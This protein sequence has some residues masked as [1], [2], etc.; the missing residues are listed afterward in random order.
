M[1]KYEPFNCE[2]CNAAD[3]E[4]LSGRD[5]PLFVNRLSVAPEWLLDECYPDEAKF[6]QQKARVLTWV[7]HQPEPV[8]LRAI[9]EARWG[10]GRDQHCWGG[11][12][13]V[14]ALVAEGAL[15]KVGTRYYA[16]LR[17]TVRGKSFCTEPNSVKKWRGRYKKKAGKTLPSIYR[18][19]HK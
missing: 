9:I 3:C 19:S 15:A 17:V 12:G 5:E 14:E 7:T 16:P 13:A 8:T 10:L 6:A 11:L 18:S 4:H 1:S 2:R